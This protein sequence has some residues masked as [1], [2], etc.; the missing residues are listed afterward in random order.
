M[1]EAGEGDEGGFPQFAARFEKLGIFVRKLRVFVVSA[2]GLA[3]RFGASL[4]VGQDLFA[5]IPPQPKQAHGRARIVEVEPVEN[6]HEEEIHRPDA[7][8]HVAAMLPEREESG[9]DKGAPGTFF[10]ECGHVDGVFEEGKW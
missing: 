6:R 5:Q 4:V 7:Q 10:I 2:C 8:H 3:Q 1:A 9:G